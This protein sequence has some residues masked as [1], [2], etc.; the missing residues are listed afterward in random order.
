MLLCW[1]VVIVCLLKWANIISRPIQGM[2]CFTKHYLYKFLINLKWNYS[3]L[4]ALRCTL[5]CTLL[6]IVQYILHSSQWGKSRSYCT[7]INLVLT[8]IMPQLSNW[9][10]KWKL[11]VGV[12]PNICS[13]VFDYRMKGGWGLN[14]VGWGSQGAREGGREG[15]AGEGW[16]R[17]QMRRPGWQKNQ[18]LI[19]KYITKETIIIKY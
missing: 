15:G 19:E 1:C 17:I 18:F 11:A 10:C 8:Q 12:P 9:C 2:G 14:P 5:H 6:C 16:S 13:F 3:L 7:S 4:F